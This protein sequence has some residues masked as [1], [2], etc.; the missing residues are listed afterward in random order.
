[1]A[2]GWMRGAAHTFENNSTR[3]DPGEPERG[4]LAALGQ[5]LDASASAAEAAVAAGDTAQ[6]QALAPQLDA[7]NLALIGVASELNGLAV[8]YTLGD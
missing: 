8:A 4:E 3:A 6:L 2:I 7:A 1:M 5:Q